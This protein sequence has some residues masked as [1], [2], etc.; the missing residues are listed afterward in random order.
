MSERSAIDASRTDLAVLRAVLQ[1]GVPVTAPV[2]QGLWRW[3]QDVE[4]NVPLPVMDLDEETR[5]TLALTI[6]EEMDEILARLS[7]REAAGEVSPDDL[8]TTPEAAAANAL[9]RELAGCYVDLVNAEVRVLDDTQR[10][11]AQAHIVEGLSTA[12]GLDEDEVRQHLRTD[13]TLRMMLRMAG[14]DPDR[15]D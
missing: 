9:W 3:Y 1:A 10:A 7:V 8:S 15:V 14:I 12:M 11:I 5:S 13:A 6:L 4:L 2:F